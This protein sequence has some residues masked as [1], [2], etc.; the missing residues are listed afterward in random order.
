MKYNI[1][2][3]WE[4][5]DK[6]QKEYIF[7]KNPSQNNFLL[8]GRQSGK[9]AAMSMR[10]VELCI[11]H[12]K[13]GEYVL[14]NSITEKQAYHMFAKALV[15]AEVK[16]A[17]HIK[18]NKLDKPTKHRMMFKNGTGILCYAAGETGEGLRGFTIKKLMPDEGSR[19]SEEYFIAVEP[20]LSVIDGSMDISSTPKGKRHKDG[21]EKYFYKCSKD[22]NY[23]KYYIS[24]EDC[25][26]H[27][28]DFLQKQKEKLS[29]LAYAQEY[30]AIFTDELKRIYDDDLIKEICIGKRRIQFSPG[31]Y[32]GGS[33]IAGMGEDECTYEVFDKI[34]QD[35]YIQT[36]NIV[37]KRNYTT[38]T[39]DKILALNRT[40]DFVKYGIDDGGIGFGVFSELLNS[41]DMKSSVVGLNNASR[42]WSRDITGKGI[43]EKKK[44]LL[45]EEMY[46]NVLV[47]MENN[48]AI[49][50]DD[51]EI[52]QSL[53]SVQYDEDGK[54]FGFDNHIAEGIIRA[55]WLASE[56]KDLKSWLMYP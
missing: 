26:R 30:L 18:R 9:T 50:L 37:E 47:L 25:P 14:I 52:K 7:D 54:I 48:K 15:Y 20:Q 3:P 36:E 49:F 27:S 34:N 1:N 41:D 28:K 32:Y 43:K 12:F 33:D 2:R 19:M 17:K 22:K 5:L 45:K 6:W 23:K 4:T 51:D 42:V 55:L 29:R 24:A 11:K 8:V 46:I 38:E 44:G 13:E 31:D 39:S 35:K 21:S 53:A 56:N 40:Y 10:A 16:Y